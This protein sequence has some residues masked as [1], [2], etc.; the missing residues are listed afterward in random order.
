[1]RFGLLAF[2]LF[3]GVLA[4]FMAVRLG[5]GLGEAAVFYTIA[6]TLSVLAGALF[7]ANRPKILRVRG[8]PGAPFR[9]PPARQREPARGQA[10][11]Q[12]WSAAA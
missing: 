7:W 9:Q 4:T 12:D 2:G 11:A 5:A 1:M 6:S 10:D 3:N 8:R